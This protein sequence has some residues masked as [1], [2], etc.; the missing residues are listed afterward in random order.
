MSMA[1][2]GC[3]PATATSPAGTRPLGEGLRAR[4][5][6][7]P[8]VAFLLVAAAPPVAGPKPDPSFPF[9]NEIEAFARANSA[10]PRLS[11][12][13]LFIGSSSIRLWDVSASFPDIGIV[14][15]GFGGATTPDV[16]HY[17]KRL[18][19]PTPPTSVIVYVGENDLATGALPDKIAKDILILLSRLR[20][21]YPRAR[22][23]FLSLKPSPIRW[24]LWPRMME[25]NAI[26]AA[27][28]GK[29]F[30]YMD[31]GK[32]LLAPD[33]LPDAQLFRP[34]GL[35][36]N[37]RGYALWTRLVDAWLDTLPTPRTVAI[38]PAKTPVIPSTLAP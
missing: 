20:A 36:M 10:G 3:A 28:A 13:T 4:G 34:D 6:I 31:V 2:I 25:V 18:L 32:V 27:R 11:D 37:P 14:N 29:D 12:A 7:A 5:L 1:N 33:G 15:R 30:D 35:H 17:Y 26:V 19:P 16:L 21:D 9:S 38:S 24:T 23:A 22:I 8:L